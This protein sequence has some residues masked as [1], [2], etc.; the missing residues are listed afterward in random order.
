MWSF[1][2]TPQ[3]LGSVALI[4]AGILFGVTWILYDDA[5]FL[6]RSDPVAGNLVAWRTEE[7]SVG[8]GGGADMHSFTK[9]VLLPVVEVRLVSSQANAVV[10]VTCTAAGSPA[11]FG[12]NAS[13]SKAQM[14]RDLLELTRAG[15]LAVYRLQRP[16]GTECRLHRTLDRATV[17]MWVLMLTL[18]TFFTFSYFHEVRESL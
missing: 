15:T 9:R 17:G 14:E 8:G 12:D 16:T 10:A 4:G 1:E 5:M 6:V 11:V 13:R 2:A 18:T 3:A 7:A